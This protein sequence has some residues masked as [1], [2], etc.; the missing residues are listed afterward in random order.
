MAAEEDA[1]L[2]LRLTEAVFDYLMGQ[3][4]RAKGL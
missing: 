3:V 4:A 1:L 2:A